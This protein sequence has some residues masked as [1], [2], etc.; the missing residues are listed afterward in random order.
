MYVY[1]TFDSY[2]NRSCTFIVHT[3]TAGKEQ[4]KS[5]GQARKRKD[6]VKNAYPTS[7]L[8][9]MQINMLKLLI[10]YACLINYYTTKKCREW[11]FFK[12]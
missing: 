9:A 11:Y 5:N 10:Q 6:R 1:R 4:K 2:I 3:V 8:K 12:W 7:Y